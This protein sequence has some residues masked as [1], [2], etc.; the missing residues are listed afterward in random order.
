MTDKL[1][2]ADEREELGEPISDTIDTL[3]LSILRSAW[4][5]GLFAI[6]TAGLIAFTQQGTKDKIVEQ[7]KLARSKAL[8]QIVALSEFDNELLDDA[9]ML[10]PSEAL[11][12]SES[13]EA[14]IALKDQLPTHLILPVVALEGYTGPI[15]LIMSIDMSGVIKGVRVIEHKETP[16]LGDKIDL[17]KSD[18]VLA[19]NGK[20]LDNLSETQWQVKKDGGEF[21]QL[22]GAT[23][24]PRAI[25]RAVY[26]A[27][28]YFREHK[29][30]IL[31]Q[32]LPSK[33][34]TSTAAGEVK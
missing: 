31:A 2:P 13:V 32:A 29:D 28:T 33:L 5:L 4:G 10:R 25:V 34:E 16:G 22:T 6:I 3:G 20:S 8:L 26:Q 30:Q 24:T 27:L 18:W 12:N 14:F 9:F 17:K 19:F 23:I 7:V 11:G 21:D 15:R 1:N